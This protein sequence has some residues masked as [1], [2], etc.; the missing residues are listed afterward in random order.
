V[1]HSFSS[2]YAAGAAIGNKFGPTFHRIQ[3]TSE[4]R[5]FV[6]RQSK[7][8]PV[9]SNDHSAALVILVVEDEWFLREFIVSYLRDSGCLVIEAE[10]GE[11]A[12][13]IRDSCEPVDVVFTDIRLSGSLSGWDLGEAFRVTHGDIPVI[14]TSGYSIE[15][16]RPV[17]G[18]LYFNK[19]YQP[20]DILN[21]CHRL[22]KVNQMHVQPDSYKGSGTD[23][24]AV[25]S[26]M[27]AEVND[28]DKAERWRQRAEE[29]RTRADGFHDP[30]SR[31]SVLSVA[32]G[33]ERM[34][35]LFE[36]RALRN[37]NSRH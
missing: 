1:R 28:F 14:Y 18:S 25:G 10:T 35:R 16:R 26:S 7:A 20:A 8:L 11:D 37:Q 13:A 33:Y 15:P 30:S 31:E 4:E 23:R 19:P 29:C 27:N 32:N 2:E 21:A 22:A 24:P 12:I 9:V 34:A 17:S 36:Q 3:A 6:P 5:S